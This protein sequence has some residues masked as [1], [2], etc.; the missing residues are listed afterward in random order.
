MLLRAYL[1]IDD[2][3]LVIKDYSMEISK[4]VDYNNKYPSK[5]G[6]HRGFHLTVEAPQNNILWEEAIK[7]YS[8]TPLMQIRFEPAILGSEKTRIISM[9]DCH[10]VHHTVSYHHQNNEPLSERV[11]ITCGGVEDSWYP[12]TVY[13][14]H[15]R[16]TRPN[17]GNTLVDETEELLVIKS[18]YFEDEEGNKIDEKYFGKAILVLKTQN[19]TG[20]TTDIDLSSDEHDYKYQG[21]LLEDDILKYFSITS[22]TT[23]IPLE[24]IEQES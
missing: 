14:E 4:H 24:I 22:D 1:V 19:G 18:A 17:E 6:Q 20:K 15:W 2:L 13:E 5:K 16:V 8:M 9:Y 11:H 23:R 10:V 3:K 7:N 21:Q 12:A